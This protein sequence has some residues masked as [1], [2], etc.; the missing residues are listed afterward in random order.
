[1]ARSPRTATQ[2]TGGPIGEVKPGPIIRAQAELD[3]AE[4]A[5]WYETQR[6]GLGAEFVAEVDHLLRRI[7][8]SPLQFPE[9][10]MG[11]RRGLLRRFPYGAYF[12]EATS[13]PQVLAV[14]HLH[15]HPETWKRRRR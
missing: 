14:L 1:M 15:R 12:M 13:R 3:I 6:P 8:E 2:A 7:A 5:L 4:A 9:I 10:G 11:V